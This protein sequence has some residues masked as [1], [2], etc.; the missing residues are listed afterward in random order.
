MLRILNKTRI[1]RIV[2]FQTSLRKSL[3]PRHY[4]SRPCF[5]CRMS[6]LGCRKSDLG[7]QISSLINLFRPTV[8]I[9]K[10]KSATIAFFSSPLFFLLALSFSPPFSF[11]GVIL[12]LIGLKK[13]A[14]WRLF[15]QMTADF[16][17]LVLKKSA[18]YMLDVGCR[19]APTSFRN[20]QTCTEAATKYYNYTANEADEEQE[21][22]LPTLQ[23][24]WGD[25]AT[26]AVY[27][28][29]IF[30]DATI[31]SNSYSICTM[32]VKNI[33]PTDWGQPISLYTRP[34]KR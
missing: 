7:C 12:E 23:K 21:H 32:H 5:K 29:I 28:K 24:R 14:F 2:S 22:R 17:R 26:L 6:N 19:M 27:S 34:S 31:G 15:T 3:D 18:R 30:F 33:F 20:T 10:T 4:T 11:V 8:A 25:Q 9:I 16:V 1:V 13:P